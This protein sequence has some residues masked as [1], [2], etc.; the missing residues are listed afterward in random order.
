[1]RLDRK[2]NVFGNISQK[3]NSTSRVVF[4]ALK[5]N[6]KEMRGDTKNS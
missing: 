5:R 6:I 4:H 3:L 1:M 2:F